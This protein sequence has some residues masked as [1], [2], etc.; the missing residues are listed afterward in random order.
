MRTGADEREQHVTLYETG[1]T[2]VVY[3]S[4]NRHIKTGTEKEVRHKQ[5]NPSL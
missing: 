1:F 5:N 4:Y 3:G 2:K